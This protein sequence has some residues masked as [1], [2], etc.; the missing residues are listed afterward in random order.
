MPLMTGPIC[1]Y[2]GGPLA[3]VPLPEGTPP[4]SLAA[5]LDVCLQLAEGVAYLHSRHV[6]HR[7]LKPDNVLYQLVPGSGK[8]QIKLCDFGSVSLDQGGGVFP[9][10]RTGT[11]R[12][13][14]PEMFKEGTVISSY[15]TDVFCMALVFWYILSNGDLPLGQYN[16]TDHPRA[17]LEA[18]RPRADA[19]WGSSAKKMLKEMW[20][21]DTKARP[22]AAQVVQLLAEMKR[23][24][25][26][27]ESST[28]SA[29]FSLNRLRSLSNS[30]KKLAKV[31][32]SATDKPGEKADKP[33]VASPSTTPR[34][35][36]GFFSARGSGESA[37]PSKSQ[38][39]SVFLILG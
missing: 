27:K 13:L 16:D 10:G 28:K 17:L 15:P 35:L 31:E 12:W 24:E 22:T 34:F 33:D 21:P 32:K 7:D 19:S 36:A 18:V 37:S 2:V 39:C 8:V 25:Q 6:L 14:A 11:P 26:E 3:L 38:V 4:L 1:N 23:T 5:R 30:N 9:P 20:L 29:P